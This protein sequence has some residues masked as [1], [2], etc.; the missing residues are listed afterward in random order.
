MEVTMAEAKKTVVPVDFKD[1]YDLIWMGMHDQ[2]GVERRDIGFGPY[3]VDYLLRPM[4][5]K[6]EG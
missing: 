5:E 4:F 3:I 6:K 2:E 1:L